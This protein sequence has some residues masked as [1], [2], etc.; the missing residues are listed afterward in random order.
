MDYGAIATIL[1]IMFWALFAIFIALFFTWVLI[2]AQYYKWDKEARE[3]SFIVQKIEDKISE[4]IDE[5]KD[6]DSG[7]NC[8]P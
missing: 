6:P 3:Q 7:G 2:N 8:Q 5:V 1:G 4:K